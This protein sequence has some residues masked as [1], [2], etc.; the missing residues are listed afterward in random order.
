[1]NRQL[2]TEAATIAANA[3]MAATLQYHMEPRDTD[4]E[5]DLRSIWEPL[6]EALL[7]NATSHP[8][9]VSVQAFAKAFPQI[10]EVRD[11]D[12]IGVTA[13]TNKLV[14]WGADIGKEYREFKI[15]G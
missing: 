11:E 10:T 3:Q 14:I 9:N 12:F 15:V 2:A 5:T 1:M 7:A 4:A 13:D 8:A 6:A